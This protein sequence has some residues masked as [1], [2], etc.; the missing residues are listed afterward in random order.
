MPNTQGGGEMFQIVQGYQTLDEKIAVQLP[1]NIRANVF[2][3]PNP[4]EMSM[5][6]FAQMQMKHMHEAQHK[7]EQH[8]KNK[9]DSDSDNE[10]VDDK[11]KH[12]AREWDDWKD[13]HPKGSGNRMGK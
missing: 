10:E 4:T 12:K 1:E 8:Q 11:K 7:Q 6:E 5:E 2:R 3:N 9:S 13:E